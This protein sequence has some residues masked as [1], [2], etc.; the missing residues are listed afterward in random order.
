MTLSLDP[1]ILTEL[2][3]GLTP[4]QFEMEKATNM[5][6]HDW[7]SAT[8][9]TAMN[10]E[11]ATRYL[12]DLYD[13]KNLMEDRGKRPNVLKA[14]DFIVDHL[15]VVYKPVSAVKNARLLNLLASLHDLAEVGVSEIGFS[16][17]KFRKHEAQ[18]CL[19]DIALN[20]NAAQKKIDRSCEAIVKDLN[21]EKAF[22]LDKRDPRLFLLATVHAPIVSALYLRQFTKAFSLKPSS[23]R[24]ILRKRV[25]AAKTLNAG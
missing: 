1:V 6:L 9:T 15:L 23:P 4:T 17:A 7:R 10:P 22:V 2:S 16:P 3:R 24:T 18:L 21:Q 13:Q 5:V 14:Y 20:V 19:A 11:A 8:K 12:I 25:G